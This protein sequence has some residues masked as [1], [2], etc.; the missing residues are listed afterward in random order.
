MNVN[1]DGG[2]GGKRGYRKKHGNVIIYSGTK[3][4][5]VG[6]NKQRRISNTHIT[7]MKIIN[8]INLDK[9]IPLYTCLV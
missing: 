7:S 9:T 6:N 5:T 8:A 1:G 2:G 3:K 4:T